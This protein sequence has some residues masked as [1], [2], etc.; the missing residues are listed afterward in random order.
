MWNQRLARVIKLGPV[1]FKD[2]NTLEDWPEGAWAK[3]GDYVR[4]RQYVGD[5]VIMDLPD[6]QKAL[7]AVTTDRELQSGYEDGFDPLAVRGWV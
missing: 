3:P 7:F 6:G 4:V 2:R 5:R 1:A